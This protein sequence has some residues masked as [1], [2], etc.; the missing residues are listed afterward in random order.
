[1]YLTSLLQPILLALTCLSLSH[2]S[3]S[4]S[5]TPSFPV[6]PF[7]FGALLAWLLSVNSF[8]PLP[9]WAY[10]N[11]PRSCSC[12]RPKPKPSPSSKAQRG[13]KDDRKTVVPRPCSRIASHTRKN[14]GTTDIPPTFLAPQSLSVQSGDLIFVSLG[15]P[16]T[17][18]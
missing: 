2:P 9:T 8:H 10:P 1:M 11:V 13:W 15:P 17:P 6:D 16:P 18:F 3:L 4:V 7:F 5:H 12:L 14:R